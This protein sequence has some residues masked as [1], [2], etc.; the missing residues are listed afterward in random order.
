MNLE[1]NVLIWK[2]VWVRWI[3]YGFKKIERNLIQ[4]FVFKVDYIDIKNNI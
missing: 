3:V 1:L 4:F 2:F